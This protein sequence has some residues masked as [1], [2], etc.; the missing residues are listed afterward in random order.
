MPSPEPSERWGILGGT[1]DPVH[2]GHLTLAR[3]IKSLKQLDGVILVPS[4][5]HPFKSNGTEASYEDRLAMLHIA[6]SGEN[7]FAVSDIEQKHDLPGYTIDTIRA[8]KD[9][10]PD[11]LFCFLIGADNIGQLPEW[12]H[13]EE[14]LR[15]VPVVAG[16]R[17]GFDRPIG[18]DGL[19]S[20]IEYIMTT[21]VDISSTDIRRAIRGGE[22]TI[23]M[24]RHLDAGVLEYIMNRKL[25][26]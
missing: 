25:Y 26:R 4:F 19:A 16:T 17:P 14:I 3:D 21:A 15:E 24:R 6:V 18:S 13:P 7:G 8:I 12:S 5:R 9:A 2:A 11:V 23:E 20:Q 22:L 10:F 1:F